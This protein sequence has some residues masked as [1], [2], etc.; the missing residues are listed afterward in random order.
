[1]RVELS[2]SR[3]LLEH[4]LKQI[5][6]N[7]KVRSCI[8][9]RDGSERG[10]KIRWKHVHEPCLYESLRLSVPFYL[11]I[12]TILDSRKQLEARICTKAHGFSGK[13]TLI[14]V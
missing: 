3:S 13:I 6:V 8:R 2:G 5:L 10:E 11:W 1:M 9:T 4:T 12:L 14:T 7:T